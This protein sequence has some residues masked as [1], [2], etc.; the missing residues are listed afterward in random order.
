MTIR[1]KVIALLV[2]L[3]ALLAA[4]Q[5]LVQNRI[6]LPSFTAL[7]RQAAL[8]DMDRAVFAIRYEVEQLA[9]SAAD[10]GNWIDT[11]RFMEKR[12]PNYIVDN[13]KTSTLASLRVD[14]L[15]VVDLH[16][17]FL[18]S[19]GVD[20]DSGASLGLDVFARGHLPASANLESAVATGQPLTGI[21][22]TDHGPM[23][24]ALSPILDG[25]ATGPHRGMMLFG[26]L[27]TQDD[28]RLI[29]ARAQVHLVTRPAEWSGDSRDAGLTETVAADDSVMVVRRSLADINGVPVLQLQ[30]ET[31]R[32]ISARGR[33][34]IG[35]ASVFLIGAGVI[36][37]LLLIAALTR[38]VLDPL[39]RMTRH[40][41]AIGHSSD[42]T[43]RLDLKRRDE[44]GELARE[45][46]HMVERLTE[47]RREL[48]DQS[49]LS[50]IAEMS[51]EVLH[52]IGNALTPLCMRIS[53]LQERLRAAP[54]G[55]SELALAELRDG[56]ADPAR[57]ADLEKFLRLACQDLVKTVAKAQVD[58]DRMDA[59]SE[60][61]QQQLID[62]MNFA[63]SS[64]VTEMVRLADVVGASAG[65]LAPGYR[66]RLT[67][68][69]DPS[70]AAIGSVHVPR[71]LLQR[72]LHI[73]M[74]LA[75]DAVVDATARGL[76]R[77]TASLETCAEGDRL[78]IRLADDGKGY[79]TEEIG[80]LFDKDGK[81]GA[82]L[83]WVAN[84][85]NALGGS[86]RASSD[87]PQRGA[88]VEVTLPLLPPA[89]VQ[90]A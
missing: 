39:A 68:E 34:T 26:R 56:T 8:T 58:V 2:T 40:A 74:Q 1:I 88:T 37:L 72:V 90:A 36:V 69:A 20:R 19:A 53:L 76:L 66:Q 24:V 85:I 75:A 89:A 51:R 50:G 64:R 81:S 11:Y 41:V 80:R 4:A 17:S 32:T 12:D 9:I 38:F 35:Y 31:P 7:E 49:F 77:I 3:F 23:L 46:D 65:F 63:R 84:A 78:S 48:V 25:N 10:Y 83:H 27:L 14:A 16:G 21:L 13:F 70:V 42:L 28:V 15:A 82:G 33:A 22:A 29:G 45:F 59:E 55:E 52:N 57:R 44:L 5:F 18:Y 79:T 47:A 43:A 86:I 87:G 62:Q 6:L 67:I 73:L 61:I 60:R 71:T 30:I 54:L